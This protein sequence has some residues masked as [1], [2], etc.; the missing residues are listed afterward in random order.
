MW[1]EIESDESIGLGSSPSQT[2]A[3]TPINLDSDSAIQ[4]RGKLCGLI[5]N[6][7]FL[8]SRNR[9]RWNSNNPYVGLTYNWIKF[10]VVDMEV[11]KLLHLESLKLHNDGNSRL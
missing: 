1:T 9:C 10:N 5:F 6:F 2:S 7:G 8:D 11:E 4:V 3:Q